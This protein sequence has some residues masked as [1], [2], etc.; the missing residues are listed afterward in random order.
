MTFNDI[1]RVFFGTHD[2]T[3]LN[4]QGADSGTQY[5][6]TIMYHD[7]T[8]KQTALKYIEELTEK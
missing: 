7:D 6:S 2:P 1:L 5:R 3:T 4:R 8:Q